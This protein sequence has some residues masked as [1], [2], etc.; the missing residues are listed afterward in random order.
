[1]KT[2]NFL[3]MLALFLFAF[4]FSS[5]SDADDVQVDTSYLQGIW[6]VTKPVLPDEFVTSYTFNADNTCSIY[7]GSPL[8]NGAPIECTYEIDRDGN[9]IKFFDKQQNCMEQYR[10]LKRASD[11]MEWKCASPTDAYTDKLLEKYKK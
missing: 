4:T 9:I 5:C 1:M 11:K 10:I 8:S 6:F 3:G 2:L 7:T